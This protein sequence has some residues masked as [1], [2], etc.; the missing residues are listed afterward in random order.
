MA[1]RGDLRIFYDVQDDKDELTRLY[2]RDHTRFRNAYVSDLSEVDHM[3]LT[4]KAT[5]RTI[6]PITIVWSVLRQA[7]ER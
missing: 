7:F 3:Q 4:S 1:S 6:R 5:L 2:N